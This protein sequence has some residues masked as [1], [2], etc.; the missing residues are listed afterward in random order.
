MESNSF[1]VPI[2]RPEGIVI[3]AGYWE[4]RPVPVLQLDEE[5]NRDAGPLR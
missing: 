1:D 5:S 4:P 3:E 2:R